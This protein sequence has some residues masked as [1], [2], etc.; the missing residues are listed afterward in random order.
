MCLH[1]DSTGAEGDKNA[2][3]AILTPNLERETAI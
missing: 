2:F 3:E 1:G